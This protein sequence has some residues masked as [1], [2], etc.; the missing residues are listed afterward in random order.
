MNNSNHISKNITKCIN[1]NQNKKPSLIHVNNNIKNNEYYLDYNNFFPSKSPPNYFL[2]TL[3]KRY[4]F[5]QH[6][7]N[8]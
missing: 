8:E 6:N 3:E 7:F 4:K 2:K 5:Y 1:I